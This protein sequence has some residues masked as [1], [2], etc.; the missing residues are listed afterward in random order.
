MA[1]RVLIDPATC[2]NFFVE[3][4]STIGEYI[5]AAVP[6][7]NVLWNRMIELLVVIMYMYIYM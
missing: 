1:H 2:I 5:A 7:C 6:G 4:S 3:H